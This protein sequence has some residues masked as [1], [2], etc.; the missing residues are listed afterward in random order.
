MQLHKLRL[1]GCEGNSLQARLL[2]MASTE[3]MPS[4]A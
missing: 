3:D 2:Q 4:L 1:L